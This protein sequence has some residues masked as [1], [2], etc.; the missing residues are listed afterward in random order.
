MKAYVV[1]HKQGDGYGHGTEEPVA[2]F[3]EEDKADRYAEQCNMIGGKGSWH[4]VMEA[5]LIVPE[6]IPE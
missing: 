5:P 6:E 2:V 1:I 4:T 3:L